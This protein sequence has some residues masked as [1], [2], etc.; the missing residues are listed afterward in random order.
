MPEEVHDRFG[1]EV[2][3]EQTRQPTGVDT[4]ET[5]VLGFSRRGLTP[6]ILLFKTRTIYRTCRRV[7]CTH[8]RSPCR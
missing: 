3:E 1:A 2:G 6:P 5:A 8:R 4:D 7:R